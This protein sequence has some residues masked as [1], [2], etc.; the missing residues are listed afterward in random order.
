MPARPGLRSLLGTLG[1]R[2]PP[3]RGVLRVPGLRSAVS[4]ARDRWGIPHVDAAEDA[5]A[6][7]ALGFCH[8]QDRA[9]QL[10]LLTRAGRG[11]LAALLGSAALPI[12][13]LS[14]TLGLRRV[15]DAQLPLL[16]DDIR[17]TIQGYVDGVNA[18]FASTPR[19]HELVLLRSA[20]TAWV[21]EDVLAFG[22]LQSLALNGNWDTELARLQILLAD[23]PEALARVQPT[24]GSWLPTQLPVGA[25]MGAALDRLSADVARLRDLVGGAGASNAWAVAGSRATGGAPLLANDPHLAPSI[26]APW[27]L[28]HLRTPDW[29]LAGPSFV[30]A[31]AFPTGHNG[32]A[33]WGIAAACTDTADLYWEE[34]D[35]DAGTA[36]GPAGPEPITRIR[37]EIQVRGAAPHV[38]EV[39]ITRRGPVVTPVLEGTEVALSLRATWL[40]SVPFRGFLDL[41]RTRAFGDLRDAFRTWPGPALNVV[42]ADRAGH[43]G[44]QLIGTLPR[45]RAGNG[46][47]PLPARDAECSWEE[48]HHPFDA[49]PFCLD[50][51]EGYVASANNAPRSDTPDGPF[52]GIDWLDGYRAARINE[53]VADRH[54]WDVPGFAELQLDLVSIPW[55]ELRDLV[56]GVEPSSEPAR[57]AFELLAD[58]DGVVRSDSPAASVYEL[59]VNDLAG[60]IARLDAPHAWRW[61]LGAGFGTAMPR[62]TFGA[63]VVSQLVATLNE[64][65]DRRELIDAALA[66]TVE[67]LTARAGPEASRWA[68]GAIRPLRLIHPMGAQGPLGR[69]LNVGPVPHGGDTNTVAQ[70]GVLPLE[71]SANPAAIPNHRTVIDL[72]DPER[73]RYVIA[74][75]QSGNPLSPHYDDLFELWQR[76]E[77]VPI[78]RSHEAV[79]AATVN[80]L[81]LRPRAS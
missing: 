65:T 63:R 70:A 79:V 51:E 38:E 35:R 41:Q 31:P 7:F 73:S 36:H 28:A 58:W 61:A 26:P 32:H 56:L 53:L 33:A 18:S 59:L 47:L 50:P 68:W 9:F 48:E 24:Y 66:R 14:R 54:D 13:R 71:P 69:M 22:V 34:I 64:G 80:R 62:T 8:G 20:R 76:G 39:L 12:D 46:T 77:G 16:D 44:W 25:P 30:G 67:A 15:A 49:L 23:G 42:Y 60:T 27:Y 21:A 78:A 11:T 81:V 2:L 6:W 74:G 37:E 72:G 29:E 4:I 3:T 40:E 1:R 10:E 19:P 55:R 52:L 75:G 17:R 5:D 57:T 43:I 45:R